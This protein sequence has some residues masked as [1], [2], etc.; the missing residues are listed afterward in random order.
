M[1]KLRVATILDDFSA[2]AWGYEWDC[3]AVKPDTWLEELTAEPVG[4]LFVESAWAGNGKAWSYHLTGTSAPR[5]AIVELVEWCKS[6]Q[7]PTVFWNKEDPPHY[8]DFLATA[9]LFDTVLTSDSTQIDRY[10]TD[11]GHDRIHALSF[12]AQPV[13]HNP[14]RPQQGFQARDV[15]FAGM[16]FAHKF[17]ERRE[18]MDML[19]SSALDVSQSMEHGLEIFSRQLGGDANYQFPAPYNEHV[20]GSLP[21]EK[22]LT[23]YKAYKVFLNVNSVVNSP[24]MCARRIFEITASGTPVVTAPS[25]AIA[26]FFDKSEVLEVGTREE[27]ASMIRSLV[28]SKELRDHTVHLGQRR[29]WQEHT[30]AHRADQ[31]VQASGIRV[32]TP[33]PSSMTLKPTISALVSTIRPQQIDHVLA[34]VGKQLNVNIELVLLSHGFELDER[35][36]R[37]KAR[38]QGIENLVILHQPRTTS[39]GACLNLAADA[40]SGFYVTKM[41]DDDLYGINYLQDQA[42]AHRYSGANVVGKQ[43]HYMY[44]GGRNAT[45]LRFEEREHR[46]TDLVMGPTIFT[47]R[48]I[49]QEVPFLELG[50]GEDTNFLRGV[51]EVGGTV[52]SADRFNFI[53]MRGVERDAHTWS[54]EE[55]ELLATGVLSTFGLNKA[56]IMF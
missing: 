34:T 12:A 33:H 47:T 49:M 11:L 18:Q 48:E 44:L 6:Q 40:A 29:I 36:V 3:I 41:D 4:L 24:S 1:A 16:Y 32:S 26:E 22:M 51:L 45:L 35:A 31:V 9:R 52:Y 2:Q 15:A 39:L 17:P 7:I 42:A 19:L 50:R 23:A 21:Y 14:I 43:A 54:V 38:D 46:F 25:R 28:R 5:P 20:V 27:S 56:H 13:V 8:E 30:Y 10:K 37:A 53:Q 55:T